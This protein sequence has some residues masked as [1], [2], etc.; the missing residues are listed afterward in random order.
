MSLRLSH[1]LSLRFISIMG[2][3]FP[4]VLLSQSAFAVDI[5]LMWGANDDSDLMGYRVF[6]REQGER[7]DYGRA[8]WEGSHTSCTI[9]ELDDETQYFFVVRAFDASGNESRNSNQVG[10]PAALTGSCGG[11]AEASISATHTLEKTSDLTDHLAYFL[12]PLG[13]ILAVGIWRRMK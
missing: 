4:L 12:L 9:H 1:L 2:L 6:S 7:Y 13:T 8:E 11:S 10:F 5:G 3:V